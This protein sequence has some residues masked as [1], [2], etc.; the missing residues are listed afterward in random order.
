[1]NYIL[2]ICFNGA[3]F[4]GFQRQKGAITVQ[5]SIEYA[6]NKLLSEPVG[7]VG[8]GRTDTGV[9][10]SSYFLNFKTEDT[11]PI[12]FVYKINK[13]LPFSIAVN[14]IWLANDDFNAR[15]DAKQRTY[16]YHVHWKKKPF[17]NEQS[18]FLNKVP[19]WEL[20]NRAAAQLIGNQDFQCFS[21]VHT[22]VNNFICELIVANWQV[23]EDKAVFTITANRFLRNMVRAIVGTLLEIGYEKF[24]VTHLKDVLE[25]KNR[26]KAGKSVAAKALFLTD[27]TYDKSGWKLL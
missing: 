26:S 2:E 4:H 5:E 8:C 3:D 1:M 6:I 17:N 25:S 13:M 19:N 24:P 18:L 12:N 20:M 11:I 21:K 27:I 14:A 15:F 10:A 23:D 16:Q 7:I 9:H 22:E